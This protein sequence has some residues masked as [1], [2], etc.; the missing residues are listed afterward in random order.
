[1]SIYNPRSH[2]L[3]DTYSYFK[4]KGPNINYTFGRGK[5]SDN[6]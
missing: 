1:M 5:R 2:K 3:V 6:D 4:Y